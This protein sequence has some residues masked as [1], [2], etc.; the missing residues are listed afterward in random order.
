MQ[1][2]VGELPGELP[3]SFG[4]NVTVIFVVAILSS[5]AAYR[6]SAQPEEPVR[7][8]GKQAGA[9]AGRSRWRWPDR[10]VSDWRDGAGEGR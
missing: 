6:G 8:W 4:V 3:L 7:S 2:R 9:T 5:L 1:L 10:R